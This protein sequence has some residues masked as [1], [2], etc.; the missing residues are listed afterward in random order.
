M[1]RSKVSVERKKI[2]FPKKVSV[3]VGILDGGKAYDEGPS[4]GEIAEKHEFGLGVPQRSW[5]REWFDTHKGEVRE[6]AL[7]F[8]L[9]AWRFT[10]DAGK[11]AQAAANVAAD[12]IKQRIVDGKEIPAITNPRTIAIKQKKG[13]NPPYTPLVETGLLLSSI[14]A[15][16]EVES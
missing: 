13:F 14:A 16:A 9:Q 4:V 1:A 10:G 2:A 11:G 6:R 12:S 3:K 8:F 5:L 7:G 15:D